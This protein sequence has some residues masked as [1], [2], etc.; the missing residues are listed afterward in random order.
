LRQLLLQACPDQADQ[1][2]ALVA[3]LRHGIVADLKAAL[4]K[5]Q[6]S[7]W[8][9]EPL[10]SRLLSRS[11]LRRA[12]ACSAVAGWRQALTQLPGSRQLT[13]SGAEK[14]LPL[15]E[16]KA[17]SGEV[18][19]RKYILLSALSVGLMMGAFGVMLAVVLGPQ[20]FRDP[21]VAGVW[22]AGFVAMCG[23]AGLLD[24]TLRRWFSSALPGSLSSAR[25]FH[26]WWWASR[27]G[28]FGTLFGMLL[29]CC[30][31]QGQG[32]PALGVA[33][34]CVALGLLSAI[35]LGGV[36]L[37]L[38]GPLVTLLTVAVGWPVDRLIAGRPARAAVAGGVLGAIVGRS[39]WLGL[40]S[41]WTWIGALYFGVCMAIVSGGVMVIKGRMRED[42]P[43]TPGEVPR[44]AAPAAKPHPAGPRRDQ[45]RSTDIL[46]HRDATQERRSGERG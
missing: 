35:L 24:H 8:V 17:S 46:A 4:G 20:D 23:S 37:L 6:P 38:V 30:F 26:R 18:A 19:R 45:P 3:A 31:G 42:S 44:K 27:W 40:G 15:L 11:A 14:P 32:Y 34:S 25:H 7:E 12:D 39:L 29:G 22:W 21:L 41:Q 43:A 33:V 13:Q 2:E 10:V 36:Y 5:N 28:I 9:I 16:T 1:V